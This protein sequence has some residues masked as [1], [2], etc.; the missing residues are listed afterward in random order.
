MISLSIVF[1]IS[2]LS[3]QVSECTTPDSNDPSRSGLDC[4]NF[5]GSLPTTGC[6]N[7]YNFAPLI[8]S[9]TPIKTVQVIFHVFQKDDGTRNFQNTPTDIAMLNNIMAGVND[10]YSNIQAVSH[11]VVACPTA[12]IIDSRIRF[13]LNSIHFYQ[14]SDAW[15]AGDAYNTT[16]NGCDIYDLYVTNN[17][18]LTTSQKNNSIH[19]FLVGCR[20]DPVTGQEIFV[21]GGYAS[22]IPSA[23]ENFVVEKGNYYVA[24]E[25]PTANPANLYGFVATN[26][27]H[28]FGHCM[29]LYHTDGGDYCCDT[30]QAPIGTTN[31]IMDYAGGH[32]ITQNQLARMH[33]IMSGKTFSDVFETDITDYCTKDESYD[34]IIPSGTTQIW[35]VDK[36]LNT[37]IVIETGAQLIIKCR[38]GLPTG[39]NIIVNRGARIFVDGGT[40]THNK[41]FTGKCGSSD[42]WG[43]IYV[44]GDRN[45]PQAPGMISETYALNPLGPGFAIFKNGAMIEQGNNAITTQSIG[46]PW[47][48]S[49]TYSGGFVYAENT[50]FRNNQ[51]TAEFMEYYQTSFSAFVNCTFSNTD[52]SANTGI[53]DWACNG[54]LVDNC[55]FSDL[56]NLGVVS[57]DATMTLTK[58]V[59]TKI[60]HGVDAT[61]TAPMLGNLQIGSINPSFGN[62]FV[63]NDVGIYGSNPDKM[64]VQNNIFQDNQFGVALTG[65]SQ[66]NIIENSFSLHDFA[67]SAQQTGSNYNNIS[68]NTHTDDYV[69]IDIL[70]F[71]RGLV[72][73]NQTFKT[74]Y[75]VH[76]VNVGATPGTIPHQGSNGNAVWNYFSISNFQ[77]INTTGTTSAFYYFHP[78]PSLVLRSKPKCSIN[79]P[80]GCLAPNNFTTSQTTG[81]GYL[82]NKEGG[83]KERMMPSTLEALEEIREQISSIDL[84]NGSTED[85]ILYDGLILNESK[86]LWELVNNYVSDED[87][88]DA[89]EL[90]KTSESDIAKQGIFGIYLKI[91]DY[92]NAEASLNELSSDLLNDQYFKQVQTIN[93]NRLKTKSLQ[94]SEEEIEVLT[95]ISNSDEASSSYAKG[96]LSN[97][98]GTIYE[99]TPSAFEIGD[100]RKGEEKTNVE[101][102]KIYPNPS[103]EIVTI[104]IPKCQNNNC[105]MDIL[106]VNQFGIEVF[107]KKNLD[108][109]NIIINSKDIGSGLFLVNLT[110]NGESRSQQ[111]LVFIK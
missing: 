91:R 48:T 18:S 36:K 75:D 68:C 58:N 63:T 61:S 87:Y 110:E 85:S 49:A 106:I 19:V 96:L 13:S 86:I 90:L 70:G 51:R 74:S 3:A 107:N 111:K 14:D 5:I 28:E 4:L 8:S 82:C 77:H 94:L 44:F 9:Q 32:A 57:Y 72:F 35:D 27:G 45:F 78:N 62:T 39:G 15:G 89:I 2:R 102:L 21:Q 69:G 23:D 24:V 7:H 16:F 108:S 105:I 22:G 43:Q 95:V 1:N 53:T 99:P 25:S 84:T 26:F 66:F 17:T 100:Y 109:G 103:N 30:H 93:L 47:P 67:I 83:P 59:F 52:G 80:A 81:G 101:K 12:H 73:M 76:L 31:N 54:V 92:E 42:K 64:M 41:T 37:D 29:G 10:R 40:I 46:I 33:Y 65:T 20:I 60:H 88:N 6:N 50:T 97:M 79:F 11:P 55:R 98:L 104:Y 34:I 71:N 56:N 38:V